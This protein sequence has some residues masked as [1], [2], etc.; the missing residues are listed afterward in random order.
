MHANL[1]INREEEKDRS[2]VEEYKAF[3][4]TITEH[5]NSITVDD[6]RYTMCNGAN[7]AVLELTSDNLL[8]KIICG[9]I[10]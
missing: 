9:G 6:S 3:I 4:R 5:K 1:Y 8:D 10:N 7:S 2:H